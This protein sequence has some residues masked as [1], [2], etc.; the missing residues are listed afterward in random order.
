MTR[1]VFY[2]KSADKS[3]GKGAQEE[4]TESPD[5][6]KKLSKIKDWRKKLSNFYFAPFILDGK[7][8]NGVEYYFHA[9]KFLPKHP[10]FA[11]T[12]TADSGKPWNKLPAVAKSMG[13]ISG[14]YNPK[15]TKKG[16]PTGNTDEK[17]KRPD[18]VQMDPLFYIGVVLDQDK[19]KGTHTDYAK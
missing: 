8:W 7:K 3:P 6:Y 5:I 4:L 18:N 15:R 16:I 12:F 2:S 11:Y 9:M 1:F 14:K 13:G 17:A 10:T 19:G